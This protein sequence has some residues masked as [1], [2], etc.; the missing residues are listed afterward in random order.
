MAR[1]RAYTTAEIDYVALPLRPIGQRVRPKPVRPLHP[2]APAAGYALAGRTYGKTFTVL[3][4]R[5]PAPMSEPIAP[6]PGLDGTNAA[7]LTVDVR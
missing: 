1:A 7:L 4:W 3:R 2:I 6:S 5:A